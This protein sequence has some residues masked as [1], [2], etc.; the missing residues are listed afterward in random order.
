MAEQGVSAEERI[1]LYDKLVAGHPAAE[2]KGATVPYTSLNGNMYNYISKDG[3]FAL[4]LGQKD[5]EAS[6]AK[7]NTTLVLA[8]GIIQKEYV[9]V[10]DSLLKNLDEMKPYFELSYQYAS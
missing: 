4:R 7:Y 10:P 2:R 1:A 8:Y 9:T 6:L 5:R 3:F